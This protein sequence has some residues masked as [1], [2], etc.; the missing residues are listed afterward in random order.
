MKNIKAIEL[1]KPAFGLPTGSVLSRLSA[2]E[3]FSLIYEHIGDNFSSKGETSVSASMIS[4]DFAKPVEWFESRKSARYV[5]TELEEQVK[6]LTEQLNYAN[7]KLAN[8]S[9]IISEKTKEY[10]TGLDK[11]QNDLDYNM[12]SGE[13]FDWV[14]EASTVYYNLIDLLNKLNKHIA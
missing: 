11:L 13:D 7:S 5:I 1:T 9:R 10:Q 8:L 3:P 12:L 6:S 2:D 4:T 14:D